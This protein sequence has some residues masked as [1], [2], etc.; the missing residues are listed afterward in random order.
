MPEFL[1]PLSNRMHGHDN[2]SHGRA[3][4]GC[5]TDSGTIVAGND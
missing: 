1:V 3:A 5:L 2:L 4:R